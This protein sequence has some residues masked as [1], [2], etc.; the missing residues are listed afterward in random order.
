MCKSVPHRGLR[1]ASFVF[2]DID[3]HNSG[4]HELICAEVRTS[5]MHQ[6]LLSF[7]TPDFGPGGTPKGLLQ[8]RGILHDL[9]YGKTLRRVC[10]S[11]SRGSGKVLISR[12]VCSSAPTPRLCFHDALLVGT[13]GESMN[14]CGKVRALGI[15][16]E[17]ALASSASVYAKAF[18]A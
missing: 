7:P 18:S 17:T 15:E 5:F 14:V 13:L 8:V 6:A 4:V 11:R 9:R 10:G 3:Q 12:L 2:T 1:T 16:D